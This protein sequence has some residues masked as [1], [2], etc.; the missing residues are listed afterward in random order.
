MRRMIAG[1]SHPIRIRDE[2]ALFAGLFDHGAQKRFISLISSWAGFD[3]VLL[4]SSGAACFFVIL[5]M[6]SKLSGRTQVLLPAYTASSLVVSV[7][8]AGLKPVLCD[9]SLDDFNALYDDM[10]HW[11]GLSTLAVVPV[12]MFGIPWPRVPELRNAVAPDIF[13]IEDGCQAFGAKVDGVPVGMAGDAGF[14][15]F[16]RGK[17]L[18]TWSGG[19]AVAS[20][21]KFYHALEREAAVWLRSLSGPRAA[22]TIL[23]ILGLFFAFQPTCYAFLR[24]L[25]ASLKET[26]APAAIGLG[27]YTN[28]QASFGASLWEDIGDAFERRRRNGSFILDALKSEGGLILPK[29]APNITPVF[30]RFP[31]V[32]KDALAVEKVIRSLGRRGIEASRFYLRP[33]HHLFDLGYSAEE[34]PNA[35]YLA[36]RLVTLPVHPL[37]EQRDLETMV[38]TI[39]ECL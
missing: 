2:I 27:R 29:I 36:E 31:V 4:A 37:V 1:V 13:V 26:N 18:P 30:N 24:P 25:I 12:H 19:C 6:L 5:K 8:Q 34:F 20:S 32:I 35:V 38:A 23:K 28:F 9:I 3:R 14:F 21:E 7:R 16:S 15:S 33:L 39:K 17:N 11:C 22:A 10:V